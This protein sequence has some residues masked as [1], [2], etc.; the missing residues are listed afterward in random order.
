MLYTEFNAGGKEYKLRL[1]T[2]NVVGLEK[3]IGCNPL[4]IF[5]KG[6]TI[7]TVTTMIAILHHS[8]QK[9]HHGIDFNETSDIFDTWLDEGHAVTDFIPVILEIYKTSG[10]I[11]NDKKEDNEK[12]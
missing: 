3:Q 5:G 12:N 8:L 10:I 6:D 9:Y 4:S 11:K 7:P 1:S 2:R